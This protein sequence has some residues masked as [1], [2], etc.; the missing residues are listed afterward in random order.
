MISY[1]FL[2]F[3]SKTMKRVILSL[4]VIALSFSTYSCR[5]STGE[6]TEE[7]LESIGEDIETNTERAAEKIEEGAEKAVEEID[8]EIHEDDQVEAE[9]VE[10]EVEK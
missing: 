9:Q 8:E 2:N 4:F 7:A 5:E 10:V 6:K 3:K 1:G